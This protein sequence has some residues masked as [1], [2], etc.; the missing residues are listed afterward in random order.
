MN[1]FRMKQNIKYHVMTLPLPNINNIFGNIF[2]LNIENQQI[3]LNLDLL[4]RLF[5]YN[6]TGN[7]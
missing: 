1:S 2:G 5:N 7:V 4:Q 6:I 3:R